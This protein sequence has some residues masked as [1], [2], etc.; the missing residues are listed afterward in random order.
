MEENAVEVFHHYGVH[1][2]STFLCKISSYF[3]EN[4]NVVVFPVPFSH[5]C[6]IGQFVVHPK[7]KNFP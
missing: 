4:N 1:L 6:T 7:D 2:S 3:R 5:L